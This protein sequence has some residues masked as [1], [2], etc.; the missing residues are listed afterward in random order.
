MKP[1]LKWPGGKSSEIV[2]F[3]SMIP[4]FDRYLEPFFGGGASYGISE[5][6]ASYLSWQEVTA[7]TVSMAAFLTE[8]DTQLPFF[9]L[10]FRNDVLVCSDWITVPESGQCFAD[11]YSNIAQWRMTEESATSENTTE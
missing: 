6:S 4:G 5:Q 1:L 9:P 2:R 3:R 8:F 11:C 10:V 7:G